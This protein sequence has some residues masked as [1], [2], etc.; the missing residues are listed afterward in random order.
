MLLAI[1]RWVW[2]APVLAFSTAVLATVIVL[3][4]AL[5]LPGLSSRVIGTFWARLNMAASF[6]RATVKGTEH[7]TPGQS[8][9]VVANHQSLIDIYLLFGATPID[10]I[11]VMK[12]E[13]RRVP[14]LGLACDRMGYIY[15]DRGNTEAALRSISAA[16]HRISNGV[17]V[18]FFPEGTRSRDGSLGTFKRGAFH[19]ATELDLPVLPITIQGT[20][21]LLPSDSAALRPG[22]ATLTIHPPIAPADMDARTLTNVVHRQMELALNGQRRQPPAPPI[23]SRGEPTP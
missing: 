2:V 5:G 15:I 11:W 9:V 20:R 4:C 7:L 10:I 3:L 13:L 1:Y 6:I 16:K 14:F 12:Q 22:H 18:V 21:D 19:L 17:S 23:H 8:Y